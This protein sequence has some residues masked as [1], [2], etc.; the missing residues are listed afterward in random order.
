MRTSD[1]LLATNSPNSPRTRIRIRNS[2]VPKETF[3]GEKR[4][5]IVPASVAAL[6]KARGECAA[7]PMRSTALYVYVVMHAHI[8]SAVWFRSP[9]SCTS[10]VHTSSVQVVTSTEWAER[11]RE[12]EW[13]ALLLLSWA[14]AWAEHAY[15]PVKGSL[16]P[17]EALPAAT[18]RVGGEAGP[19][20]DVM[21]W[22]GWDTDETDVDLHVK[23][24]TGEEVCYSH[25]RSSSTGAR[26]SR[27]FTQ[28][29]GPEVYTLPRAPKGN[30]RVE[31]NYFASHQASA[32]TGAT[33][34]V[35]WSI[36]KMG[37]FAN[38][39]FE[40][41]SVR[42]TQHKQRQQVLDLHVS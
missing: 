28:G 41:R 19:K 36:Q 26:V 22:L 33:S 31:T 30:Y 12:I 1:S 37:D 3:A 38:E 17:E 35:I 29:F 18:Y 39:Q 14:V 8:S 32:T 2:G 11:F 9:Q 23:E 5:A 42:L 13:P 7:M 34:A 27:D 40:F 25:N 21:V 20:L 6:T 15:P 16:W 24:P 10:Q 4:V